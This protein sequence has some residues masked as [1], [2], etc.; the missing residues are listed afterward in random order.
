[1]NAGPARKAAST[2]QLANEGSNP[3][4][5]LDSSASAALM[6]SAAGKW[7]APEEPQGASE[8]ERNAAGQFVFKEE[9]E[10]GGKKHGDDD[11]LSTKWRKRRR[12]DT[13]AEE[14]DDSEFE[15]M[16][17]VAGLPAV[18]KGTQ[19][20]QSL[21]GASKYASG[22]SM[23]SKASR[24]SDPGQLSGAKYKAKK[25]SGD[26]QGGNR[27]EP[28]AYWRFDKNM[29]NTRANKNQRAKSQLGSMVK[30]GVVRGNKA[31]KSR[32]SA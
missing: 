20:A 24:A 31:K 32:K 19:G 11:P 4:N 28:F 6:R 14:S 3:M 13:A 30:T 9:K 27:V 12:P 18:L 29:L 26:N 2:G 21:K 10:N 25:A 15:D 1:M 5:L 23:K 16:R 17:G 22:A 7:H 8:F